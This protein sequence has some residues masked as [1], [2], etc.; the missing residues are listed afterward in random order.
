MEDAIWIHIT[1][2]RTDSIQ[3]DRSC[4]S[5]PKLLAGFTWVGW[6]HCRIRMGLEKCSLGCCSNACLS[7]VPEH[8]PSKNHKNI[9]KWW[10]RNECC[11]ISAGASFGDLAVLMREPH[12]RKASA[13][14]R[15]K[16]KEQVELFN[17]LNKFM[18]NSYKI[19]Q[20]TST[21]IKRRWNDDL[22]CVGQDFELFAKAHII[23]ANPPPA[24]APPAMARPLLTIDVGSSTCHSQLGCVQIVIDCPQ[25]RKNRKKQIS[26]ESKSV[27]H[28]FGVP[29]TQS[30][31][32]CNPGTACVDSPPVGSRTV[33]AIQWLAY[34]SS[35]LCAKEKHIEEYGRNI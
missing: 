19:H 24:A 14:R 21:Y 6:L 33:L 27:M 34:P 11:Q 18:D 4:P 26:K 7:R 25:C 15:Q 12:K 1:K 29:E 16:W 22:L 31:L 8:K 5:S 32:G 23:N 13:P 2:I 17:K 10:M 35:L 20:H 30:T 9:Q 28:W 3:D